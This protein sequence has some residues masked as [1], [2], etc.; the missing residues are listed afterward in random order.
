[1]FDEKIYASRRE[2]LIREVGEGMIL[3]PGNTEIPMN[4]KGNTFR[5][6]QDSS[7]LYFNGLDLPGLTVV[8]DCEAHKTIL[9]ADDFELED[10]IWMGPQ[11]A[12]AEQAPAVGIEEVQPLGNLA[13]Y[14]RQGVGKK[15][16]LHYLPPYHES[17]TTKL[18]DHTG[19][20]K[21]KVQNCASET[22]TRAVIKQRSIKGS[23]EIEEMEKA[24]DIARE[25]H[26]AAMQM[27]RAGNSE[28]EIAGHIEGIALSRGAGV[29]FQV[30]LSIHGE[31]LH[32]NFHGNTL[33]EGDLLINDSGAESDLHYASDITRT[34][35]VGG[36]FTQ[37]QK[38]IYQVVFR[39]QMAAIE[40]IEPGRKNI[41]I[42][43]QCARM[44]AAGLKDLGLMKGDVEEAVRTGAHAL[45]FPHGLGHMLGLDVH[46]MEGLGE[47]LVGYTQEIKRSDQF[48]LAYLRLARTL[49]AGY[50][51]T[52]EPGIYFIPAL[53]DKWKQEKKCEPFINYE[54]V[55]DY[56]G[57]GGIR[58]EDD[59]LVTDKGAH[60]LGKPIPKTVEEVERVFRQA[61]KVG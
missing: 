30:I 40:A 52:V 27:A 55:Q 10:I 32:N 41:D 31:I 3:F 37:K 50:V 9:F 19:W 6:R 56:A 47:N 39:A 38:D 4:Y 53:I 48:G 7:F 11:T 61:C 25:M 23:E 35:P 17:H 60:I 26:I 54:R 15:R 58:I 18:S 5:F 34:V 57:F 46:D 29:P 20:T 8:I 43:L 59:V 42:H 1:M 21:E 45:F 24:V 36:R 16:T 28:K 33:S 22:L 12:L 51:L 13:E 2:K 44:L 14:I 49:Q